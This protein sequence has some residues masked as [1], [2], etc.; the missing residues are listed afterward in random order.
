MSW[1]IAVTS[2]FLNLMQR[3]SYKEL[4]FSIK[5]NLSGFFS[6]IFSVKFPVP[7]P[8]SK[9]SLLFIFEQ[10]KIISITFS[11]IRKF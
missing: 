2:L 7:G 5:N 10:F 11:S 9:T 1:L 8:T 3:Y 4:S 6:I